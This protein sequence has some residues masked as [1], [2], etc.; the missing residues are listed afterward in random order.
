M[1][2]GKHAF[3]GL[4][5]HN[6]HASFLQSCKT[7][8]HRMYSEYLANGR[9]GLCV[10]GC[11]CQGLSRACGRGPCSLA[12]TESRCMAGFAGH[13]EQA[14]LAHNDKAQPGMQGTA[15][16]TLPGTHGRRACVPGTQP[17]CTDRLACMTSGVPWHVI[18]GKVTPPPM[19]MHTPSA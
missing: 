19:Q 17:Q 8:V 10:Q 12:S 3:S 15:H 5:T 11:M 1:A 16:N 7:S 2:R 13:A 9:L 18:G 14:Y 4:I 6:K